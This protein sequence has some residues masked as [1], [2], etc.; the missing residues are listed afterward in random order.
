MGQKFSLRASWR[1]R[2]L[3]PFWLVVAE[4]AGE[5]EAQGIVF[6]VGRR[7]LPLH[8]CVLV[9]AGAAVAGGGRL[10]DAAHPLMTTANARRGDFAQPVGN[11]RDAV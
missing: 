8:G 1:T 4:L 6:H 11:L 5:A 10:A 9:Q 3:S 7:D 2:Q